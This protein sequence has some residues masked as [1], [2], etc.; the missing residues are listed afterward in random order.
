MRYGL[1]VTFIVLILLL[2]IPT[3]VYACSSIICFG[4]IF[5]WTET[6]QINADRDIEKAE[7]LSAQ[8]TEESRILYDATIRIKEADERIAIQHQ[9]GLITIEQARALSEAFRV[10]TL[11]LRDVKVAELE[12][13]F[14]TQL[15]ALQGQ[16]AIVTTKAKEDA[17]TTRFEM[18]MNTLRFMGILLLVIVCLAWRLHARSRGL[19]LT[20]RPDVIQTS[21]R[22]VDNKE[23][24][25]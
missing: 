5:G 13:V 17:V 4:D 10:Q 6:T 14:S 8:K 12:G 19:L 24:V 11:S 3:P 16:V 25:R 7:I 23:V 20:Q 2:S 22:I 21:W 1:L 9:Q 15:Q 18:A